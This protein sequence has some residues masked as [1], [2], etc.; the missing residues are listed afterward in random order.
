VRSNAIFLLLLLL[1]CVR[2]L[3]HNSRRRNC[4]RLPVMS[5]LTWSVECFVTSSRA[6]H[7]I[8]NFL[9]EQKYRTPTRRVAQHERGMCVEMIGCIYTHIQMRPFFLSSKP[10]SPAQPLCVC[11]HPDRITASTDSHS[12]QRPF[13]R[14]GR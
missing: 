4:N 14:D 12:R 2:Q 3:N 1:P 8:V 11:V 13:T 9:F 6:N 5:C 10:Y 7:C